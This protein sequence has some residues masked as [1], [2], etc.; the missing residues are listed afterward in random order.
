MKIAVLTGVTSGLG[1]ELFEGLIKSYEKYDEYWLIARREDRLYELKSKFLNFNIVTLPLDLT[2]EESYKSFS[3]RLINY[4][5]DIKVLINCAGMGKLG[6]LRDMP[7]YE[8]MKMVDLNNR[9][10]TVMTTLCLKYMRAGSFI[11]NVA[12]IA[13]FAPNPRMTVYCST[14][15]YVLSFSKSLR[16]ELKPLKINC[17]AVCPGPMATE[18]L[19]VAGISGGKS[20]TF[21]T[22]PYCDPKKV[23][24]GALKKASH[25]KAVYTNRLFFKF[26]RV[27]AKLLPHNLVMK[28][29]KT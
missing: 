24:A 22:L 14:K 8:Q 10:L 13:A 25:G 6:N 11:V 9:A 26:Y 12:S 16:E 29:S 27:L 17:L 21:E 19:D 15:A 4:A 3:E 18:F 5:P 20:K 23:A 7:Y 1:R 2:D 28:M